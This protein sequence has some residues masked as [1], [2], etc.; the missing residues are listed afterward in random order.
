MRQQMHSVEETEKINGKEIPH[1]KKYFLREKY[2]EQFA[3]QGK[4]F[5]L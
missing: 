1:R 2:S 5:R 3:G 4:G